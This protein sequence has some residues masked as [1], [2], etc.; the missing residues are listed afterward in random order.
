MGVFGSHLAQSP[1]N[2]YVL[3]KQFKKTNF[4]LRLTI[5]MKELK[6]WQQHAM[7]SRL[8]WGMMF[9]SPDPSYLQESCL[10]WALSLVSGDRQALLEGNSSYPV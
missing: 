8:A 3:L 10:V 5:S 7:V 2:N 1:G 6:L 9:I 4:F